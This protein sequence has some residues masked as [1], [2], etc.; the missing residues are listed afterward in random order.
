VKLRNIPLADR[1]TG[2]VDLL[3][4]HASPPG[5]SA[6]NGSEQPSLPTPR[7]KRPVLLS[8]RIALIRI[9]E[10]ASVLIVGVLMVNLMYD[11]FDLDGFDSYTQMV[12]IATLI[13]GLS[14]QYFGCYD[15]AANFSLRLGW[16]RV[17]S[18]WLVVGIFL[19]FLAFLSKISTDF[20]RS[21]TMLWFIVELVVIALVR[22]AVTIWLRRLRAS[23][24]FD[25]RVAILGAGAQGQQ[26]ARYIASRS[27]LTIDLIGFF[28]ERPQS[29]LPSAKSELPLLGRFDDLI[30]RVRA[31]EIDQVI[32]ALPLSAAKRLQSLVSKL[33]LYPVFIRLAPDLSAFSFPQRPTVMLG[34]I[35]VMNI[36]DCPITG[37]TLVSKRLQDILLSTL[38]LC[39]ALPVMVI[40][41]AAIWIF[42]GRPILFCQEREGYNHKR[43]AIWKFRSMVHDTYQTGA[44]DQAR[45]NDSRITQIGR[46]IRATSID[47]LPQLYN[48]LRGEMSL[49]GPRPHSPTTRAGAEYF[50]E[51]VSN[52][53]ARQ[54]VKPGL[55]G[56]AQVCGWRGE[57]DTKEKLVGRLQH[58]LF[59]IENYSMAFDFYILLRTAAT[60]LFAKNA[61]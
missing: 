59:Y 50:E 19:L 45:P 30:E 2:F 27:D 46:I 49:V 17:G 11:S 9:I 38:I 4:A 36:A 58:D 37:L 43:F 35:P 8:A 7:H 52:Y 53:I 51:A 57:T 25:Q 24:A 3:H 40:V 15:P 23:G 28:D 31:D 42:D 14:A 5:P 6:A 48:V 32:V 16:S 55:T 34:S 21:W 13:F 26:L 44:I 22:A 33:S 10:T 29:R 12:G 41:A 47:E 61:H 20:S 56:W 1:Q 54:R 39:L 60:V 18:A